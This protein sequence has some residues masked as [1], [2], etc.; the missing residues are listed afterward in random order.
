[1]ESSILRQMKY[2]LARIRILGSNTCISL[3]YL[4]GFGAG[5]RIARFG[6]G[7]LVE[8]LALSLIALAGAGCRIQRCIRRLRVIK[9]VN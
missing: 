3:T 8:K 4:G 7:R 9:L 1:M 5:R 2:Y 6:V